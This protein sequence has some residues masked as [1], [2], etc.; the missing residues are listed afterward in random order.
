MDMSIIAAQAVAALLG[1]VGGG[2]LGALAA[3]YLAK[4]AKEVASKQIET[5]QS[6]LDT[7]KDQLETMERQLTA[8]IETA[9]RAS[10]NELLSLVI[11]ED[12]LWE[13]WSS[14]GQDKKE[15]MQNVFVNMHLSHIETL[16]KLDRLNEDQIKAELKEHF[17]NAKYQN[18]WKTARQHRHDMLTGDGEKGG[19][20]MNYVKKHIKMQLAQPNLRFEMD[21]P[22]AGFAACFR[23]SQAKR[24]VSRH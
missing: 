18:F 20:F 12:D 19:G 6:Q 14:P 22:T 2:L 15:F 3:V 13:V 1:S 23:A 10:H 24:Y 4:G 16:F 17:A 21:A 11:R 8:A 5:L 7:T 9:T